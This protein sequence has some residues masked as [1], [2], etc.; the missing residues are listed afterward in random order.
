MYIGQWSFGF[1]G[2][3][4]A[5]HWH[6]SCGECWQNDRTTFQHRQLLKALHTVSATKPQQRLIRGQGNIYC[7]QRA[8]FWHWQDR[9]LPGHVLPVLGAALSNIHKNIQGADTLCLMIIFMPC[10]AQGLFVSPNLQG[11][12]SVTTTDVKGERALSFLHQD[13]RM[14]P[15]VILNDAWSD[16]GLNRR[17]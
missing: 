7:T 6:I 11:F 8:I 1:K 5:Q 13:C 4:S 15:L 14:G 9:G 10:S 2:Q 3:D 17:T 16:D 12:N